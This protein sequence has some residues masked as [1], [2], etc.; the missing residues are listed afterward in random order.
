MADTIPDETGAPTVD[1]V[2]SSNFADAP[3]PDSL[4]RAVQWAEIYK[5][6]PEFARFFDW[7]S[8]RKDPTRPDMM[9]ILHEIPEHFGPGEVP[10]PI[11]T[12]FAKTL[13][14]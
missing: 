7:L 11:R 4:M 2:A 3:G 13:S 1:A 14:K 6:D 9:D 10:P 12:Y 5:A 8:K